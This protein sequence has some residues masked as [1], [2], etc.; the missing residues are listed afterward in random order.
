MSEQKILIT[1]IKLNKDDTAHIEFKKSDDLGS[2]V[3]KWDGQEKITSEFKDAFLNC[4]EGFLGCIPELKEKNV[5]MNN[6]FF[7]YNKES[8]KLDKALYSIKY[9][10]N[11]ANNAVINVSTPQLP[12]YKDGFDEKTFCISGKHEIALY[13]VIELAEKYMEGETRTEQQKCVKQ[14]ADGNIV[15]DFT[16]K[17]EE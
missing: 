9:A 16:G 12:I 6:M 8:N 10:F 11:P 1:N 13:K 5:T 17:K 4:K 2:G 14:D 15:V 3:T 7:Y